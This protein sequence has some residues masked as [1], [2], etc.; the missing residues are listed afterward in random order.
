MRN[1]R[2][3]NRDWTGKALAVPV[4]TASADLKRRELERKCS[5]VGLSCLAIR[6]VEREGEH[7]RVTPKLRV[8]EGLERIDTKRV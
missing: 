6:K 3:R 2:W 1:V 5:E 8:R 7:L 4:S